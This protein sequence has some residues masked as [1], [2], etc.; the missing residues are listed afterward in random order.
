MLTGR[1]HTCGG[2]QFIFLLRRKKRPKALGALNYYCVRQELLTSFATINT[3]HNSQ[4]PVNWSQV[5]SLQAS[6]TP[7]ESLFCIAAIIATIA[8]APV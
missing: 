6:M 2:H 8:A 5:Q 1:R 4:R 7:F 3:I